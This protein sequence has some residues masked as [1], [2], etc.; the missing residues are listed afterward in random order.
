MFKRLR[1]N[2]DGVITI[3]AALVIPIM[4]TFILMLMCI[5]QIAI[6]EM[7]LQESVSESTQTMAHYGYLAQEAEGLLENESGAMMDVI[8]EKGGS[9]TENNVVDFLVEKVGSHAEGKIGEFISNMSVSAQTGITEGLVKELYT[10]RVGDGKFFNAEGVK[11]EPA[12]NQETIEVV[13]EVPL[14]I[15]LPFFSRTITIKKKSVEYIW[16]GA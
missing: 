9:V 16:N 2:E 3:E 5:V 6:A 15:N 1:E 11:V 7:A 12:V 10:D 4:V 13:A 14:E 8:K